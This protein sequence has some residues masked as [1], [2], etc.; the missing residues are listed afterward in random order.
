MT[1]INGFVV[2]LKITI[3]GLLF[4]I[5]LVQIIRLGAIASGGCG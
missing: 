1:A 5:A 2:A 4:V 3:L